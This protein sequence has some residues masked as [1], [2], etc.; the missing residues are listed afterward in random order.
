MKLC[1]P[2]T[3]ADREEIKSQLEEL[4]LLDFDMIELRAD[5]HF[6][7]EVLKEIREAFPDK[8][9]IFTF[10]TKAEGGETQP[11]DDFLL[12]VYT[13]VA[14]SGMVDIIDLELEGICKTN[15]DVINNLKQSG[16]KLMISNHDFEKTPSE[17]EI[18]DRFKKMEALGADMAKIAVM[19]ENM[20]DVE[21]LISAA[22]TANRLLQI[23][24]VAISMGELGKK[25][26]IEGEEFGSIITFGSLDKESA[27]GQIPAKELKSML[28]AQHSSV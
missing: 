9:L 1:I 13:L 24:I 3:G 5:Y 15:P 14:L 21:I 11:E 19:P 23:P 26:R 10:R 16:V 12:Y 4:D 25:T 27:S 17:K 7:M 6:S 18:T 28:K 20:K 2:I 8:E 22:K